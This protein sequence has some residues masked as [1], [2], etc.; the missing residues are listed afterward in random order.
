M[1]MFERFTPPARQ[2]VVRAQEEARALRH[3]H[4]G[5]EHILLGLLADPATGA[6][7]ALTDAGLTPGSV[8]ADIARRVAGR[9]LG[10][11]DADALRAIGIDLDVVREKVE[12]AFGPGAL[13]RRRGGARRL[14]GIGHIPVSRR[15]K[16]VLE[17]SLRE[18][19]HL[20]HRWIGPDHILLGLLREGEGVAAQLLRDGGVDPADL[21]QRVVA[22]L[23]TAA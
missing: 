4:L 21:R 17:L 22:A 6:A 23:R 9:N 3:D 10:E 16:K 1:T 5:T 2:V 18:A 20:G 12:Q 19:L 15:A 14:L 8:R 7:A 11:H 13:Q